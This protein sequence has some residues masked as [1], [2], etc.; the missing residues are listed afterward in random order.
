MLDLAG[1]DAVRQR[2]EGAVR[3]SVAVAADDRRAR[4]REALLRADHVHDALALVALMEVLDAEVARVGCQRLDLDAAVLVGDALGAVGRRHVVVDDRERL[5][6]R[7][8]LAA[9]HP[10]AFE[11]LR[12]RHLVHEMA[13][14]VE[15][16][17]AVVL[18]VD[19]VVVEDL[20]VER[21][22]HDGARYLGRKC[23]RRAG[24]GTSWDTERRTEGSTDNPM[25]RMR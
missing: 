15:Q 5:L 23:C 14:D 20:V 16:A 19:N 4:Q 2:A 21:L 6:R 11:G 25:M 9:R 10:K 7:A 1:A 12:A 13:V 8:H 17:G 3:G 18:L 24:P 22:G